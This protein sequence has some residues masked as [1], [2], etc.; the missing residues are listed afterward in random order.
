MTVPFDI[1]KVQRG[2][3]WGKILSPFHKLFIIEGLN[4]SNQIS[5][6]KWFFFFYSTILYRN[7]G[8]TGQHENPY[9]KILALPWV[10]L[11]WNDLIYAMFI[12]DGILT[13]L[14]QMKHV[15]SQVQFGMQLWNWCQYL[16][17]RGTLTFNNTSTK[18]KNNNM[19][20]M[21]KLIRLCKWTCPRWWLWI[22]PPTTWG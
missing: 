18:G 6:L 22:F 14:A 9:M 20:T 3:L 12:M 21:C 8:T 2:I 17:G 1:Y 11:I 13:H 5:S 19:C 10:E 16:A 4:F 7:D 15:H